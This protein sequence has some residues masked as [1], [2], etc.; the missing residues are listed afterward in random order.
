METI[1]SQVII[2][3]LEALC[4]DLSKDCTYQFIN[5]QTNS[6]MFFFG[7]GTITPDDLGLII[8]ACQ[9]IKMFPTI[10]VSG[11]GINVSIG[12]PQ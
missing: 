4:D 10:K 12:I 6:A 1:N 9:R 5:E 2:G 3:S 7:A 8:T 11:K